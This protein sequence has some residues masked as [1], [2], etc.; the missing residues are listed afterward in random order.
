MRQAFQYLLACI[1]L[2][3]LATVCDAQDSLKFQPEKYLDAVKSKSD[4]ISS[5]L[6][7]SSE[8]L[9]EKLQRREQKL[10][11]KLAKKDS[12]AAARMQAASLEK[13][14]KLQERLNDPLKTTKI[15][16]IAS[17]DTLSTSLSFLKG[18]NLPEGQLKK[19]QEAVG[20]LTGKLGQAEQIKA[21][22]RERQQMLKE[23]LAKYDFTKQ[24]KGLNKDV[25]YYQQQLQEYKDLL[26][27]R[28]KMEEKALALLRETPAFKNFMKQN[29]YLAQLFPA[30]PGSSNGAGLA[31][32]QTRAQV[33]QLISQRLGATPGAAGGN[34]NPLQ[35]QLQ[36][37]QGQMD[38]LKDKVNK[39][40]GGSSDMA[41][42]DGFRPN[43]Q[44][45]KSF[46]QRLEFGFNVQS[47]SSNN[48]LPSISDMALTAGYKINDKSTIGLG[49]SYKLGWGRPFNDIR[50]SS[51][52]VGLR[53]FID[54][55]AKGS[56]WLTGGYEMNY[57]QAFAKMD[58]LRKPDAWQ[59]SGLIGLS[60]KY[61]V[62]KKNGN[63]QLLWDFLSYSQVPKAPAFK[64]RVGFGL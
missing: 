30:T 10:F 47:Q 17:L 50:I 19:A 22:V 32:L 37:A 56:I 38:A 20:N 12:A 48:F 21:F 61:K 45:T 5:K 54:V 39:L 59:K 25:Y 14:S 16:Y 57:L 52:G 23:Q 63:L 51:E 40:G 4:N 62:G 46:L 26:K 43:S 24:L 8:K 9:L 18:K 35:A 31:G 44:K 42:P 64:F 3:C 53:S 1:T 36:Q 29:S 13:Y 28:K 11:H 55:K 41:M 7:K 6:E 27:D 60:K 2:L 33:Q 15:P 58:D 49:A 34:A